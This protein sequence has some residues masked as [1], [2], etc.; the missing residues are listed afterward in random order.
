MDLAKEGIRLAARASP[1]IGYAVGNTYRM[2]VLPGAV[3]AVLQVFAPS[4]PT[5]T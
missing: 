3:H 2:P 5:I 4:A 1:A